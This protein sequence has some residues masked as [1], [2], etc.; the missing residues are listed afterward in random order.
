MA[1]SPRRLVRGVRSDA[2]AVRKAVGRALRRPSTYPG[3]LKEGLWTGMHIAMYPVGL[4]SE[5]LE[6]DERSTFGNLSARSLA[7][8]NLNCDAA[9]TPIIMLHG[10]LHNRSGFMVMRR[11][12]R[13]SGFRFV[14]TM[15]YNV[16][17]NDIPRLAKQLAKRV[18]DDLQ[19]TGADK[20]YLIGHSYGGL[21]ARYYIQELGGD[22]TVHT[23]VTMGTPHGGTYAAWVGRGRGAKALRPGS[24][25]L[26]RLNRSAREMPVR[27]V[28][29]YSNLDSLVLPAN[30]AKITNPKLRAKNIL[31]KDLGHMSLLIS[32]PVIRSVIQILSN[33][34]DD[35]TGDT[36]AT[37]T[38]LPPRPGRANGRAARSQGA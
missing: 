35:F 27:F 2:K 22:Q 11:N 24:E 17:G 38:P 30:N 14:D 18:E 36:D 1:P 4:L 23:C 33:P 21:I 20:V 26:L 8:P 31:V 19:A 25:F 15:N 28:S 37:V 29:Y 5:A 12:L 34:E 32:R 3:W 13:R 10:Y 9:S 16:I 6:L 7:L